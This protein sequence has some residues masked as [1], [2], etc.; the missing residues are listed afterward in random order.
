MKKPLYSHPCTWVFVDDHTRFLKALDA[1]L[2]KHQPR[3][4]FD[5]PIEA[6]EFLKGCKPTNFLKP[7]STYEDEELVTRL[8]LGQITSRLTDDSRFADV[9]VVVCDYSM[10]GLNGLLLLEQIPDRS[11][12]RI[13]L[14]GVADEATAV[15]AFNAGLID[16]FVR[17]GDRDEMDQFLALIAELDDERMAASQASLVPRLGTDQ[18][19]SEPTFE[20]FYVDVLEREEVNEYYFSC[21]PRGFLLGLNSGRLK[22]LLLVRREEFEVRARR[23]AQSGAP[24]KLLSDV[25]GATRYTEIFEQIGDSFNSTYDWE[26]NTCETKPIPSMPGWFFGLV[27]NPPLGVQFHHHSIAWSR[28]AESQLRTG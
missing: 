4:M 16:R 3:K 23:L 19:L 17:K 6:L 2:P 12:K 18:V 10:P 24:K 7:T 11:I 28:R 14:T 15:Q 25:L 21:D 27:D 13:L 9:S 26:G 8:D 20:S 22:F 1:T 5:D